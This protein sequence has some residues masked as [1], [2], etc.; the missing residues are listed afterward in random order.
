MNKNLKSLLIHTL[1]IV[2]PT[3]LVSI[4]QIKAVLEIYM[5]PEFV[6]LIIIFVS[7]LIKKLLDEY[8]TKKQGAK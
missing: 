6:A 5:Q 3:V 1:I 8:Q 4:E 2:W 7:T